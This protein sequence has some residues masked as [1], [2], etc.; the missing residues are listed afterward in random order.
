MGIRREGLGSTPL[1]RL[2]CLIG[3]EEPCLGSRVP[4]LAALSAR[5]AKEVGSGHG[6][7]KR[8]CSKTLGSLLALKPCLPSAVERPGKGYAGAPTPTVS[9]ENRGPGRS[10]SCL[11]SQRE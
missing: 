7:T 11:R 10:Q 2:R 4:G 5:T 9:Q 1:I 8:E 3:K 6:G